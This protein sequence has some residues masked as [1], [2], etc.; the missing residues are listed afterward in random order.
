MS[1]YFQ[2]SC[3]DGACVTYYIGDKHYFYRAIGNEKPRRISGEDYYSALEAY[4]NY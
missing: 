4:R 1:G 3:E 2:I